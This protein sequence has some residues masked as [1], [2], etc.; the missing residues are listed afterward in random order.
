MK[1]WTKHI[2]PFAADVYGKIKK[3]LTFS[4]FFNFSVTSINR[5]E[6]SPKK[7]WNTFFGKKKSKTQFFSKK[8]LFWAETL[9]KKFSKKNSTKNF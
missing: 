8:V 9:P 2:A 7:S 3:S 1:K 5:R 6:K 4:L